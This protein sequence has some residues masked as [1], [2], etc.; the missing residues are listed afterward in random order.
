[1]CMSGTCSAPQ[2]K[3]A[4]TA[5]SSDG[6]RMCSLLGTCV[7]CNT[8]ADCSSSQRCSG[9]LGCIERSAIS[10]VGP[11]FGVYTV[12]VNAGYGLQIPAN[13]SGPN[14]DSVSWSGGGYSGKAVMGPV[15]PKLSDSTRIVTFTGPAGNAAGLL[16]GI[17]LPCSADLSFDGTGAT[18]HWAHDEV[19][20]MG[21]P[22]GMCTDA[23]VSIS[24]IQ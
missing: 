11:L 2:A 21:N 14:I 1:M 6:G 10:V 17:G 18:L 23:S 19:D 4:G 9:I 7:Q 13:G 15:V 24:A 22:L 20:P 16:T 5:C 8:D 12:Q 3:T